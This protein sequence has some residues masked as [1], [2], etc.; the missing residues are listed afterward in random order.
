MKLFLQNNSE[1]WE[2]PLNFKPEVSPFVK[3]IN[4]QPIY[5]GDGGVATGDRKAN[6]RT[7]RLAYNATNDNG[8]GELSDAEYKN[9]LNKLV[10]FF[11]D[12]LSPFYLIDED[13][14]VQ[15]EVELSENQDTPSNP[16]ME[17]ILG[18][19][20]A[21]L[22]MISAYWSDKDLATVDLGTIENE[23]TFSVTNDSYEF[24]FPVLTFTALNQVTEFTLTNTTNGMSFTY[25]NTG[26]SPGAIL[27][28]DPRGEGLIELNG[29]DSSNS[30]TNQ[31]G[32]IFLSPGVNEFEF[33]SD[34]GQVDIT[35][36]FRRRYAH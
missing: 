27:V 1:T 9:L 2:L 28:I 19:N 23:D 30:W 26:F 34:V 15:T 24:A 20:I 17:Y 25:S 10:G 3:R 7:I 11:Q 22:N 13:N 21:A 5:R 6:A 35:L 14:D 29:V 4:V 18:N 16:G 12:D 31:S 8:E 33:L 36:G 32:F